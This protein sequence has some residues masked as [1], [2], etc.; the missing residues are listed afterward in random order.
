MR[1]PEPPLELLHCDRSTW[2]VAARSPSGELLLVTAVNLAQPGE[3][4]LCA[5]LIA[6]ANANLS[7]DGIAALLN[8]QVAAPR[9]PNR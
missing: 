5:S 3:R 8:A 9:R 6:L 1:R 7:P 4:A 2:L